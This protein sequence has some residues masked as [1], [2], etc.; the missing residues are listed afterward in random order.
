MKYPESPLEAN[1][2]YYECFTSAF[3]KF[4]ESSKVLIY[5]THGG[6]LKA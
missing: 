6:S 4:D 3:T 5:V 1:L 2:R